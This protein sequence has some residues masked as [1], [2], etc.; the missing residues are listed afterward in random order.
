[1]SEAWHRVHPL[2]GVL[3]ALARAISGASVRWLDSRPEPR[4]R[5][6][7]ANHSSHLDVVVLWAALPPELRASTRPVAAQ[8]YW[9]RGR[10]R[11]FLAARVFRAVLIERN[12]GAGAGRVAAATRSIERLTAA[13]DAGD[14]LI[15]FP[16][17]TRGTGEQVAPFKSGLF[18]LCRVRPGVEL[19]PVYLENLNRIL[20]KGE[21]LPVPMLSRVTFGP[22]LQRE[23][24]EPRAAFLERARAA[25][26]RLREL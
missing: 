9:D 13:I 17:G 1:M 7:F 18:H 19:L 3:A 23:P 21:V 20:P 8:D 11:R 10:L 15:V 12:P 24:E 5:I 14:S 4:Q 22:P 25:L 26:V 2:A 6:Y 16:E